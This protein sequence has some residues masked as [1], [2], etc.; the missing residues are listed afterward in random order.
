VKVPIIQNIEVSSLNKDTLLKAFI[1][2]HI[3]ENPISVQ[4]SAGLSNHKAEQV[5]Q[6]IDHIFNQLKIS[7]KLPYPLFIIYPHNI[8]SENFVVLKTEKE[9]SKYYKRKLKKLKKR[10]TSLLAKVS[11]LTT[12]INNYNL[13]DHLSI[14]KTQSLKHRTLKNACQEKSFYGSILEDIME[15]EK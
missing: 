2:A 11:V 9:L 8:I 7:P 13:D 14:V 1:D 3:G 10:E 6:E 12:R 15:S 5:L 4:I